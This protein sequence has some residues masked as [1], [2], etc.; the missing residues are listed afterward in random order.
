MSAAV[1]LPQNRRHEHSHSRAC[2]ELNSLRRLIAIFWPNTLF[3]K[4]FKPCPKRSPALG[5]ENRFCCNLQS[6][7]TQTD[8]FHAD[9][10]NIANRY[11]LKIGLPVHFVCT[12]LCS[13]CSNNVRWNSS[14]Y[15]TSD[16][17]F[18]HLNFMMLDVFQQI[19]NSESCREDAAV[20]A[21]GAT[22][23]LGRRVTVE[24]ASPAR[25]RGLSGGVS[26]EPRKVQRFPHPG[27]VE[28]GTGRRKQERPQ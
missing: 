1:Q 19:F 25:Y 28:G 21:V 12:N 17:H 6:Q 27:D 9:Y 10:G 24:S 2:K 5:F 22:A 20:Q 16:I 23:R 13:L 15:G 4:S 3:V 8:I 14:I 18:G 11:L 7:S 26:H